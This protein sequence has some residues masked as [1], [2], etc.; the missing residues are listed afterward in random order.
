MPVKVITYRCKYCARQY[1]GYNAAKGCEDKHLI[2][3]SVKAKLYTAA[4]DY[5]Y[6][7]EVTFDGGERRVYNAED[8]GG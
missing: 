1:D 8:L 5:P 2:P 6:K 3:V 7:V 4:A